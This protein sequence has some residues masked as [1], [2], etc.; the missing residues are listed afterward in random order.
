MSQSLSEFSK[1][2]PRST[3]GTPCWACSI[4]EAAEINKAW[5]K[6]VTRAQIARWLREEK[7]YPKNLPIEV[8]LHCHF[9]GNKHHLTRPNGYKA[10]SK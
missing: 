8:R 4:P 10:K 7:G 9:S 2:V 6:N 5:N 3:G 1:R